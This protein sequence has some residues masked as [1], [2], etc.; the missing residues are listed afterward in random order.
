MNQT[1]KGGPKRKGW[2][3]A[4]QL[5][6]LTTGETLVTDLTKAAQ[7][8]LNRGGQ[9]HVIVPTGSGVS[10]TFSQLTDPE[11]TRVKTELIK[12]WSK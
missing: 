5:R 11:H 3:A 1:G 8:F 4:G 10:A 9:L 7:V 6:K 12:Y 2:P